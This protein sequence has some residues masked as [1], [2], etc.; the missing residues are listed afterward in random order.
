MLENEGSYY[1]FYSANM[2]DTYEYAVGYAVCETASGPC[3]KPLNEPIYKYTLD[4]FG[5]GGE[6]FFE[7]ADG[8]LVMAYHGWAAPDVGYPQGVRSLRI[9]PLSFVDGEPVITGPT[10]DPQPLF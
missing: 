5:P 8:D 6:S 9:D 4:V 7:Q 10:V 2:W 3:E 1:L